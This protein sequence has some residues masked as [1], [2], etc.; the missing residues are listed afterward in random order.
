MAR[1][2]SAEPHPSLPAWSATTVY[3]YLLDTASNPLVASLKGV[4]SSSSSRAAEKQEAVPILLEARC[5]PS[6]QP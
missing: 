2:L 1:S 4:A 5:S 6:S 3:P